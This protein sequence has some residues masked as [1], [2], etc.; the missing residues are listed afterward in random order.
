MGQA[1]EKSQGAEIDFRVRPKVLMDFAQTWAERHGT[2]GGF[3]IARFSD[4]IRKR[5]TAELVGGKPIKTQLRSG[6]V[7]DVVDLSDVLSGFVYYAVTQKDK[8]HSEL[9]NIVDAFGLEEMVV[10]DPTGGKESIVEQASADLENSI[11]PVDKV[12]K[13][14]VA[15][16]EFVLL[17]YSKAMSE[18]LPHGEVCTTEVKRGELQ[19]MILKLLADGI[20]IDSM[21]VWSNGRRPQ[22]DVKL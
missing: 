18:E 8:G 9:V 21:K 6:Q 3:S 10:T 4:K 11:S 12:E 16:D 22:I 19:G 20:S 14:D 1:T 15:A 5:V 17:R 13:I 7:V 2:H